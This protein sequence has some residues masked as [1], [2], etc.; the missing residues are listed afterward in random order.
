ME[1]PDFLERLF[2]NPNPYDN[3]PWTMDLWQLVYNFL[4]WDVVKGSLVFILGLGIAL[5]GVSTIRRAFGG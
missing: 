4:A 5:W 2:L 1:I 3:N